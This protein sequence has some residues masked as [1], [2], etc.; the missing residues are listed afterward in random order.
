[1]DFNPPSPYVITGIQTGWSPGDP[2]G[3]RPLRRN[4]DEWYAS[5]AQ[6]DQ[7]Q[8]YLFIQALSFWEKVDNNKKLSFFQVTGARDWNY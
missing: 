4:V 6:V 1:M 3:P 5:T 8:V 2:N 7:D